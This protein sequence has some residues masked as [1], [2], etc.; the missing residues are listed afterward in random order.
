MKVPRVQYL[1]L[2]LLETISKNCEKAFSKFAAERVLDEMVNI[3]DDP[4]TVVNNRSKALILI[5]AWRE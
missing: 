3:V 2:V 1:G 4:Q 5:E